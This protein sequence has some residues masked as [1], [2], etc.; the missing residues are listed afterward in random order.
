MYAV[1]LLHAEV[2]TELV[3]FV[4]K[5]L[6]E[7][8]PKDN[9]AWNSSQQDFAAVLYPKPRTDAASTLPAQLKTCCC[10]WLLFLHSCFLLYP[11]KHGLQQ[12]QSTKHASS[13]CLGRVAEKH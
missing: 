12:Q 10:G 1:G 5:A 9:H 3:A 8:Y 4:A 7:L 11:H 13:I 6:A 2:L